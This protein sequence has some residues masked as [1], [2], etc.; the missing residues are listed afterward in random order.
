MSIFFPSRIPCIAFVYS[1]AMVQGWFDDSMTLQDCGW[2]NA[3]C[4]KQPPHIQNRR[5]QTVESTGTHNENIKLLTSEINA[6]FE[7]RHKSN[8]K[9]VI[10]TYIYYISEIFI[11][12]CKKP[13]KFHFLFYQS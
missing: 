8:K 13:D 12:A 2:P 11:E 4:T 10:H 7:R 9:S 3:M 5:M 1:P 6:I